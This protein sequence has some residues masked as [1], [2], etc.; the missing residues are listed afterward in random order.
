MSDFLRSA[1]S[2]WLATPLVALS[3]FM[4][5][6]GLGKLVELG[7][8]MRTT[9]AVFAVTVVVIIVV[10]LK[11]RSRVLPTLAGAVAAVLAMLPAFAR[12]EDGNTLAL[13]T[14]EAFASLVKAFG[15]GVNAAATTPQGV[16]VGLP[17]GALLTAGF[18]ALF[19][20]CD[21]LAVSLRAAATSGIGLLI[22]WLPAI[23]ANLGVSTGHFMVA[24]TCWVGIMAL[25]RKTAPADRGA[26]LSSGALATAATIALMMLAVPTALSG[27]GWGSFPRVESL[28]AGATRLNLELDLR[29]SLTTNSITPVISYR[30]SGARP[31]AFRLYTFTEFDGTAWDREEPQITERAA[32]QGVLWPEP[33][34]G[35]TD[36]DRVRIDIAV[37]SLIEKSL[38]IPTSPRTI[39]ID[40][41]W[42][43]NS[44]AD[45]VIG[46][47]TTTRDLRY[48]VVTDLNFYNADD[49]RAADQLLVSGVFSD[50]RD[51]KYRAV[52][53]TIDLERVE[54][55]AR[56]VT[57]TAETRYD[58][59]LLIQNHLRNYQNFTYDTSVSPTG[60]DAVS[61]FLDNRAG[62]CVQFATT[63][64]VML[65]SLDIP[66]RLA[67]G[68]LPGDAIDESTYVI[69]GGDAHAW[70]EVY[71]PERGW[72]RFEPTP[73]IQTGAPPTWANPSVNQV[74]VPGVL[75][76]GGQF[77]TPDDALTDLPS[78]S[79]PTGSAVSAP[80]L[81]VWA[82]VALASLVVLAALGGMYWWLK[83]SK[84]ART[85]ADG[86]EAAW[87]R[88]ARR[89]GDLAWPS[90]L[91]PFEARRHV[92]SGIERLAGR[93]LSEAPAAALRSLAHAVSLDRYGPF[94]IEVTQID[95]DAWVDQVVAE[96]VRARTETTDRPAR[97]GARTAP[98]GAT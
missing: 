51:P 17:L 26:T 85:R 49:L 78:D 69:T 39:E 83:K 2:P 40:G 15:D 88:L 6:W 50:E 77:S 82:I 45:E 70:P 22:P 28:D 7:A 58:T 66:T 25:S 61:S 19:V 8:W 14:G 43:Y 89:I 20:V 59:A 34:Y 31:N 84:Y 41:P 93:P 10:R 3:V 86:P 81:P 27:S 80:V 54:A 44:A 38:P 56:D 52:A 29:N 94:G 65:R 64:M 75:P 16:E 9:G 33:V 96:A 72:V 23:A 4:G 73:S 37:L 21:H 13:P 76:D 97:G 24:L 48:T 18:V 62:Y 68:F 67:V 5:L 95:L 87:S 79:E 46:D 30:T 53:P 12:D 60:A 63:M 55:L 98:R 71:F 74:P 90:S 47:G 36:R 35:W 57:A 11:T 91:T 1:R 42:Q 92:E 32:T